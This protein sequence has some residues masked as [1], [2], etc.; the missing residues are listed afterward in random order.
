MENTSS[1][2]PGG[3]GPAGGGTRREGTLRVRALSKTFRAKAGDVV[4]VDGVSFEARKGE[5]T[6][7]VG[8]SGSGKTTLL[9][10][11]GSLESPDRGEISV[12]GEEDRHLRRRPHPV[13]QGQGGFRLPVL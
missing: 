13:P 2:R 5:V 12:F 7:I 9:H 11:I 1:R 8:P 3:T 10:L 4:A 6:V